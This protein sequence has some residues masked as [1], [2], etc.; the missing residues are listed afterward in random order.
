MV[1]C[2]IVGFI[3]GFLHTIWR[4]ITLKKKPRHEPFAPPAYR[5]APATLALLPYPETPGPGMKMP[6]R[7]A[8]WWRRFVAVAPVVVMCAG[9]YSLMVVFLENQGLL[10]GFYSAE[11]WLLR[12]AVCAVMAGLLMILYRLRPVPPVNMTWRRYGADA[13]VA[14]GGVWLA[15]G[16]ADLHLFDVLRFGGLSLV[17]CGSVDSLE[18][19][20]A[21]VKDHLQFHGVGLLAIALGGWLSFHNHARDPEHELPFKLPTIL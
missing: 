16:V 9:L 3:L 10:L 13:L 4:L 5:P 15:L 19:G 21:M 7:D 12:S 14:G 11:Q 18:A 8:D 6:S 17:S 2:V 20:L 1:C